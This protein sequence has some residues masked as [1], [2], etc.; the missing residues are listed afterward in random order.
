MALAVRP[1][2]IDVRTRDRDVAAEAI[3]RIAAHRSRITFNDPAAVDLRVRE[4]RYGDV[5]TALIRFGGVRYH[6]HGEPWPFLLTGFVAEGGARVE[7]RGQTI[8]LPRMQGFLYPVGV[9]TSGHY[10]DSVLVLLRLP[11]SVAAEV[12]EAVTGLPADELRFA[13]MTPV[14]EEARRLWV[15]TADFVWR[16]LSTPG[17]EPPPLVSH[18][19]VRLTASTLIS[20]FPNTTMTATR[21][22]DGGHVAPAVLRRATAF[23]EEHAEE[24]LTVGLIAAAAGVGVRGLQ[25]AFRRHLDITPMGYLRRV[26]L[27]RV[28]RELLTGN[29][30]DGVTVQETA[31][32]WGFVNL[33]RFAAEYRAEYGRTPSQTLRG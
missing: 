10:G 11:V 6:A 28:H 14:S 16:Q 4:S 25:T 2:R 15:Q 27:D 33:G 12:A 24:S 8:A 29:P 18:Q 5:D 7:V 1:E 30:A 3:N 19:L 31:R 32:R 21:T 20:V 17:A 9:P 22:N 13:G 23:I 26:R